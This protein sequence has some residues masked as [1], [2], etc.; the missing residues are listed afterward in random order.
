VFPLGNIGRTADGSI[1][2]EQWS[3]DLSRPL[4]ARDRL[5]LP[6][7]E[8]IEEQRKGARASLE[9]WLERPVPPS[10]DTFTPATSAQISERERV[11]GGSFPTALE[12]FYLI[13]D[14]LESNEFRFLGHADAYTVESPYLPA[15]LLAWDSDDRDDFV[16][17]VSLDGHDEAVYRLD[18]HMD[19]PKPEV[20][21]VDVREY[22]ADRIPA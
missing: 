6:S 2:P 16:V 5:Q 15:L 13:T 8:A 22:L 11:L 10:V 9:R 12:Q 1:W 7:A 4:E 19:V 20:I 17:V 3:P 14:G 21:A 18:V